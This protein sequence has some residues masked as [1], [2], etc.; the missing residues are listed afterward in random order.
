MTQKTYLVAVV[1]DDNSVR[2]AISRLLRSAGFEARP[3]GSGVEF[4]ESLSTDLPD[5]AI[6][7]L[8]MPNMNGLE[9]QA[10]ISASD[11]HVPVILITAHDAPGVRELAITAGVAA[12]L[13]K[14][15]A[16]EALLDSIIAAVHQRGDVNHH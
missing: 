7:D 5:C 4:L 11:L 14:P 1:D 10:R 2:K 9:V 12:Y 15:L 3:F 6:V 16:E 13:A 8:H